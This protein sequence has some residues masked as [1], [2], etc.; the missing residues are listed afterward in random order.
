MYKDILF[1]NVMSVKKYIC[2]EEFN[3]DF[4]INNIDK[5]SIKKLFT[6]IISQL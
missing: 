2:N 6:L 1:S 5:P 4:I 3:Y